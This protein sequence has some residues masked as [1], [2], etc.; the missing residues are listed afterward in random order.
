MQQFP[1]TLDVN[2]RNNFPEIHKNKMLCLLR[3]KIYEHIIKEDENTYF[4][5]DKINSELIHVIM[6]ELIQLGWKCK[7]SFGGT[8]LF[9][10][11][12]NLPKSC[13]DDSFE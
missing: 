12:D 5:I 1:T 10:Y 3:Q 6:E 2:N 7:L 8:A 9:I 11:S 13:W 4:D